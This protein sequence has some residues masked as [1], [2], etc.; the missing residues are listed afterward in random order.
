M[1]KVNMLSYVTIVITSSVRGA[2]ANLWRVFYTLTYFVL[3]V[4]KCPPGEI[5]GDIFIYPV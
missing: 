4:N 1:I 2:T 3:F 5:R